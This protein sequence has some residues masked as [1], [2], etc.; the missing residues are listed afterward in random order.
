MP[1]CPVC[2]SDRVVASVSA[3][4]VAFCTKCG[5]RWTQEDGEQRAIHR[6]DPSPPNIT[7]VSVHPTPPLSVFAGR[8]TA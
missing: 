8:G 7:A 3:R 4:R 5:A 6:L 1:K 2:E